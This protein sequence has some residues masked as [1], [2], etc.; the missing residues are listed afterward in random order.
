MPATKVKSRWINGNLAFYDAD[1]V[2]VGHIGVGGVPVTL[3]ARKTI[4]QVNAGIELLPAI[5]GFKWRMIDAAMI[6]VGGA[7]TTVTTID[8]RKSTRLNSSHLA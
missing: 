6:A 5:P 1:G 3:R 7:V 4:A 2:A 8:N